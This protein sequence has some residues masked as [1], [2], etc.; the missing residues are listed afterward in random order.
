MSP[1]GASLEIPCEQP[2]GSFRTDSDAI[3]FDDHKLIDGRSCVK[4]AAKH[5]RAAVRARGGRHAMHAVSHRRREPLPRPTQNTAHF[6]RSL[7]F[8]PRL[9]VSI[10]T[11]RLIKSAN[12][13]C[14]NAEKVSFCD[15]RSFSLLRFR[16][17]GT[18]M[19]GWQRFPR[20]SSVGLAQRDQRFALVLV[21]VR[22]LLE[23]RA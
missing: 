12:A 18:F 5:F 7:S 15:P 21:P 2:I 23:K 8:D 1:R 10:F 19:Y 9:I 16:R 13:S 6:I 20:L 3:G 4:R 14:S 11:I 22:A 17:C